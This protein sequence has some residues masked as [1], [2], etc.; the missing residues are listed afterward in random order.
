[1]K[2]QGYIF[3][4]VYDNE[5]IKTI[6]PKIKGDVITIPKGPWPFGGFFLG[7]IN[8]FNFFPFRSTDKLTSSPKNFWVKSVSSFGD[9]SL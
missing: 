4:K 1:M 7:V 2:R 3:E 6:L 5:N 9:E 8:R